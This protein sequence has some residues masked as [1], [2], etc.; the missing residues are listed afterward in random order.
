MAVTRFSRTAKVISVCTAGAVGS[1]MLPTSVVWL[2]G[3]LGFSGDGVMAGSVA[4][5]IQ[6]M[7][8]G[9]SITSGSIFAFCQSLTTGGVVAMVVTSAIGGIG[10]AAIAVG[11]LIYYRCKHRHSLVP[12]D[13]SGGLNNDSGEGT[14][15]NLEEGT[16]KGTVRGSEDRAIDADI[17][18]DSS[19]N[20][21]AEDDRASTRT[22]G[23]TVL[24]NLVTMY[25]DREL[26]AY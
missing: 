23:S 11:I 21:A 17:C 20:M 12:S 15:E 1:V 26:R 22:G 13:R 16:D 25:S 24:L 6:S 14:D 19:G 3:V 9:G 5:T 18:L 2:L 8:Y 4:A 7:V 10:A